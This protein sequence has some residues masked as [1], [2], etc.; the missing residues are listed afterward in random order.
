M[1][2]E[3]LSIAVLD[4]GSDVVISVSGELD[5][6]TTAGFL[7]TALPLAEEGHTL[8][9]DLAELTFCDSSGLGSFVRLHKLAQTAGGALYLARL[10][11][12]IN[13]T[14]TL[15]MLHRLL[16]IRDDVP[17]ARAGDEIA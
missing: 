13:S 1:S 17:H 14:I 15:T 4:R 10:Q 7:A 5:F 6:G 8:I 12:Q 9:L 16:L 2:D 3:L 11:P